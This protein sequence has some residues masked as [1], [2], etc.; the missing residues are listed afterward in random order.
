MDLQKW[1]RLLINT[2]HPLCELCKYK[3]VDD[4]SILE[5]INLIAVGLAAYNFKQHVEG[6]QFYH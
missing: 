5:V 3:F 6:L 1:I 4:L 2:N